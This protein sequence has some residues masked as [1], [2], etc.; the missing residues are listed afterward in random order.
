[1]KPPSPLVSALGL[2]LA[3]AV[4]LGLARFSYALLLPVMRADLGWS[5]LV[6]GGMNTANAAGYL[7]GALLSPRWLAR[8]PAR[9]V[10]LAGNVGAI[11]LLAAHGLISSDAALALL[12]F[13]TGVASAA[14]FVSGGL[15]AARLAQSPAVRSPGLVL[16]LYYG[17][18]GLGIVAS[19]LLVPP[20]AALA[21]PHAWQLAWHALAAAA[22][23]CTALTAAAT[24]ALPGAAPSAAGHERPRWRLL[25]PALAGYRMFGLGYIGYMTF[26]ITL[27]REQHLAPQAIVAFYVLLGCGVMLSSR[28]WAGLLQRAR[29]GGA[30][31]L[32]NGLLALATALPVVAPSA[33][34]AF[35]S[36]ALFGGVFLSVVASTTA[37]VRHN[38]PPAAWSAGIS[39]FTIVFAAGQ[40]AGPSLVGWIADGA[41]GLAGGFVGSALMLALGAAF[42]LRQRPLG[43]R[44]V[45]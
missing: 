16:G 45:A 29:G 8:H 22:A 6:A 4:S 24:R 10:L 26:V 14:S 2:S 20:L 21:R 36:G 43:P 7:V 28:L 5:Y 42:A 15:L 33:A 38:L 18:T 23:A 37:L 3:A 39:A 27:L 1:M 25:V 41:H 32:L 34:A 12:R 17:G 31:A 19:A 44:A 11:V 13:G 35:A 30:L 9:A 40:I